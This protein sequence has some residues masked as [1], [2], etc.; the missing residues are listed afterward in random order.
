MKWERPCF[1]EALL[2]H[3]V[4]VQADALAAEAQRAQQ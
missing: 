3:T 4:G 2:L 1:I